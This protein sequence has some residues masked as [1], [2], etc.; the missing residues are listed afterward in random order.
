MTEPNRL[1]KIIVDYAIVF[2]VIALTLY[3]VIGGKI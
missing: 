3:I 2:G 1:K